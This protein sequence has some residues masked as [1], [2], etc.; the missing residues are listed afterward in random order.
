MNCSEASELLG[1]AVDGVTSSW[2]RSEFFEHLRAC[3]TCRRTYELETMAKAVVRK[4]CPR[5][6]TP[7]QILR[8]V[9]DAVEHES[10]KSLSLPAWIHEIVSVRWLVPALVGSLAVTAFLVFFNQRP[11][12]F[13]PESYEHTASND[14][15][16]Q[17]LQ[18]FARLQNGEFKPAVIS[19]KAEDVHE[20]LDS[21]G[22]D[23][24][25]VRAMDCCTSYGAA[26]SEYD[27][28]RLAHVVYT[29]D[30]D[31]MYVYQVR[32]AHVLDGST[33]VLPPAART[34]LK[35]T[36]W[37]TDPHHPDCNVVL[38]TTDE[39]LCAAVSSMKKDEM[40]ALL[41]QN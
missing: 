30:D 34:A 41:N 38:W 25:V 39:T 7:P 13:T 24:A 26:A 8:S 23:F 14:F 36:G 29:L 10:Q 17:S 35:K 22:R 15:I 4:G 40:L 28:I 31:M 5:V 37:Y 19:S 32:K 16:H 11:E 6:T 12:T 27:G 21:S 2:N 33:F 18:N 1:E 3:T 20:Y 9:I